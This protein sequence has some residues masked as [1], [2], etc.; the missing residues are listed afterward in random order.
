MRGNSS[1]YSPKDPLKRK[2]SKGKINSPNQLGL[3]PNQL[4]TINNWFSPRLKVLIESR[5]QSLRHCNNQLY[6]CFP[7]YNRL[8]TW[9]NQLDSSKAYP[10]HSDSFQL[11]WLGSRT[12]LGDLFEI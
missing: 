5:Y 3:N 11:I 6:T 1:I 7:L 2:Q 12:I 10:N 8:G 9:N 4:D